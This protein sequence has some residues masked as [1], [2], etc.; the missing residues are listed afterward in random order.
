MAALPLH[1]RVQRAQR[2]HHGVRRAHRRGVRLLDARHGAAEHAGRRR[3]G[4]GALAVRVG[5]GGVSQSARSAHGR[6]HPGRAGGDGADV[7]GAR[8]AAAGEAVWVLSA[9]GVQRDVRAQ[10]GHDPGER[11]G[12][13][14]AGR[15]HRCAVRRVLRGQPGWAAAVLRVGGAALSVGVRGD[16]CV[17]C[18]AGGDIGGVLGGLQEGE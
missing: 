15:R 7:R 17:L 5:G 1:H 16:D 18:C 11:G 10:L 2:R 14:Q 6:G 8:G 4:R 12:S 9:A 3:A 13:H